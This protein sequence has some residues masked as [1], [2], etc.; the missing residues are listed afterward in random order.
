MS[1]EL[2]HKNESYL[3]PFSRSFLTSLQQIIDCVMMTVTFPPWKQNNICLCTMG[4]CDADKS[5][6]LCPQCIVGNVEVPFGWDTCAHANKKCAH[7]DLSTVRHCWY[8]IIQWFLSAPTTTNDL[9]MLIWA[10]N[11][12]MCVCV[13]VYVSNGI[14]SSPQAFSTETLIWNFTSLSWKPEETCTNTHS[15]THTSAHDLFADTQYTLTPQ[16]ATGQLA[17]PHLECFD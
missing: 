12:Q 10:R 1:K 5:T 3:G 4:C 13:C 7:K 9:I 14:D 15:H 11:A 17:L 6:R 8:W 2:K 16:R